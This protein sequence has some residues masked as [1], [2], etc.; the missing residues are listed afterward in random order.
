MLWQTRLIVSFFSLLLSLKM[1][2][3]PQSVEQAYSNFE[4]Y[5][6]SF[7]LIS[8][9]SSSTS[10]ATGNESS[11]G[12][13]PQ[14]VFKPPEDDAPDDTRG[15]GSRY[16]AP[17]AE[18]ELAED[19]PGFRVFLP[20]FTQ[21]DVERPTFSAYIPPT[22]AKKLFFSL[23]DAE[24]SYYYETT[25]SLP[26]YPGLL[27]FQLPKE[28]PILE[29]DKE[30]IWSLGL[31]CQQDLDPNDPMRQGVIKKIEPNKS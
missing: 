30:Y 7:S 12:T 24:E 9:L 1:I 6:V 8:Q 25:L 15:A 10:I 27:D 23:K 22:K 21:I 17:C 19:V 28:A 20:V 31:I 26:S 18:D 2:A 14:E 5:I 4:S 13:S 29:N 16:T 11:L 3:I